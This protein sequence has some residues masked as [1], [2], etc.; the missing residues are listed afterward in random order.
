[1]A[2]TIDTAP[3]GVSPVILWLA[4]ASARA[5]TGRVLA[6]FGGTISVLEGW[7]YGPEIHSD[8]R[9]T[10][11]RLDEVLSGLLAKAAPSV[12]CLRGSLE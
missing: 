12:M 8:E 10:P 6:V 11:D 5:V 2:E 3:E 7:V 1:M 4:G 9:W